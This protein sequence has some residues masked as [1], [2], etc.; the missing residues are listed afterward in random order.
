MGVSDEEI[1]AFAQLCSGLPPARGVYVQ[2]D[3]ITNLFLT[4][5]D[6]KSKAESVRTA[7]MN[8]RSRWW[9]KIRTLDDLKAFLARYPDTQEGN[10]QCGSDL[11]GF[12]AAR[13]V[14]EL[15]NLV[16]YFEARGVVNQEFLNHWA[17]TSAYRD[18]MGRVKGLDLSVYEAI[19]TRQGYGPIKPGPHLRSFI[20]DA[21]QRHVPDTELVDVVERTAQELGLAPRELERRIY[22]YET[23]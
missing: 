9:D 18:F 16:R 23:G 7:L 19:L 20:C 15:R 17:K 12:R 4:V 3:Y 6:Y 10:L 14:R 2:K 13:R 22:E 11:W 5:L 21:M 8:Y 1:R